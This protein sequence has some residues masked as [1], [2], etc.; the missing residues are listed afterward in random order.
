MELSN[1]TVIS[2]SLCLVKL[3]VSLQRYIGVRSGIKPSEL[4]N[5]HHGQDQGYANTTGVGRWQRAEKRNS[6]ERKVHPMA[7]RKGPNTYSGG[8]VEKH[9]RPE[10][11]R[12]DGCW[13][14]QA[15]WDGMPR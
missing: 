7:G 2:A 14:W 15:S 3:S 8:G 6:W 4:I 9:Y 12:L 10:R 11:G 1:R 5:R 13:S